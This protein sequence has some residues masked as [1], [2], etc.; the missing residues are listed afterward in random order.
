MTDN[1]PNYA[2]MEP[3]D[4]KPVEEYTTHERRAEILQLLKRAGSPF[5]I[6]QVRLADRFDV[7]ES[8]I[9]RD[10]DRL[11]ESIDDTLGQ[12][13]KMT[14]RVL[15]EKTVRELQDDGEWKQAWDVMMDWNEW[16]ADLG[17]QYRE[18]RKSE[19]GVDVSS[20]H[21]EVSYQ[22][23]REGDEEPLP[24]VETAEGESV[25]HDALGFTSAPAT[26]EIDDHEGDVTDE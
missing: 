19:L 8:T 2:A 21:A 24:T 25:D 14:T 5:A 7:H 9:S 11:R 10:M 20:R 12:D 1:L 17:E 6:K 23:V 16:L 13:A 18:P 3:P 15:L 22:V 26:I 4:D